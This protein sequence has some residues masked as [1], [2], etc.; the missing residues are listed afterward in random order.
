[1]EGQMAARRT[2][3][4]LLGGVIG[5]PLFIAVVIL[6]M[7]ARTGFNPRQHAL[8]QLSLGEF[9]W[10][11]IANFVVSG[12]LFIAS[13]VG[14]RRALSAGPGS[15]W[16]P[17][18]F[19][20]FGLG[21]VWG[22][23]FA[24]DPAFGFPPGTPPGP[25]ERLSWHGILHAVAPAAASLAMLIAGLVFAR[26]FA[27]EGRGAWALYSLVTPI[28]SWA[29]TLASF[30]LGDFRWMFAGGIISWL[31]ASAVLARVRADR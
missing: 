25:P 24:A 14:L 20:I 5:G 22:G 12:L 13:A 1:M 21:L 15:R 30:P 18:L 7:L 4:L 10:V 6:Q 29:L 23:V 19:G 11:Q 27:A 16:I 3:R 8:S 17:R 2:Q 26:R 31:W 28:A 9:G